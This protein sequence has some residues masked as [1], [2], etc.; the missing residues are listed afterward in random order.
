MWSVA[1]MSVDVSRPDPKVAVPTGANPWLIGLGIVLIVLFVAGVVYDRGVGSEK[2]ETGPPASAEKSGKSQMEVTTTTKSKDA[3]S[4]TLL[5]AILGSGAALILVGALYARIT[6][7]KLPGGSELTLSDGEKE[8]TA[9]KVAETMPA[10][11]TPT[12]IA[13]KAI[14]ATSAAQ[15]EKAAGTGELAPAV[16]DRLVAQVTSPG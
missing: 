3:P 14:E 16:I 6:S 12:Q 5:T 7:I 11:S 8:A 13:A 10:D 2:T 4:E 15:Q 1:A 9:A